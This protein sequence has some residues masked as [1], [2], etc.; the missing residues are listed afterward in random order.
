MSE[1][2]AKNSVRECVGS[3][4]RLWRWTTV[5]ALEWQGQGRMWH[6]CRSVAGDSATVWRHPTLAQPTRV[7]PRKGSITCQSVGCSTQC[8]CHNSTACHS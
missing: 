4:A 6:Q 2:S 7:L 1:T 5:Q 3:T 8:V